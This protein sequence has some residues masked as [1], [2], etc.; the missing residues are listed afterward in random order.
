MCSR[1]LRTV[2][3]LIDELSGDIGAGQAAGEKA[4]YLHLPGGQSAGPEVRRPGWC[5]ATRQDGVDGGG[6]ESTGLHL[7]S[8]PGRGLVPG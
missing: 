7:R 5:P 1:W 6:I 3:G 2:L 8:E 4:E